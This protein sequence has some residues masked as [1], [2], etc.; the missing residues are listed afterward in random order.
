MKTKLNGI[1]TL[2]LAL[3]VQMT[4]A[5][6]QTVTGTVTDDTGLPLPGVN[7]LVKGTTRGVQTDFDG[8]FAIEARDG[9]VLVFSYL[10]MRT[11]E[12][13][14]RNAGLGIEIILEPD[15]AQLQEVVVTAL[16]IERN[17]RELS[18]SVSSLDNEEITKTRAVNVATA[19]VGK[20][21]GMQINTVN[22]GV[23]PSTRVVL[24]GNRSLLGNNQAL[25]VV[26][27][28]PSERGV[29]DRINPNDIEEMTVLKGA[30]ASALYGS[31]AANGVIVI[32]TKQ[33]RG[34][35]SV[36]YNTSL[37]F[38]NVAYL[39]E[40]QDEF[41]AGGFP[42]GTLYPLE[43]VNWGPRFDG[44]LVDVS[45]TYP[46][47][48]VWQVPFTPIE[49]VHKDFFDTGTTIRNGVTVSGGD[50]SGD[51]LMSVDH[52]NV[53][54]TVPKDTY[55]RTNF[56]FKGSR[57]FE[58]LQVGANL[59]FY[60]S[61]S[62]TVGNGGRQNRPVYWNVINTPL[63]VPLSL[64]KNWRT[65]EFTRNE[66]SFFR[67]YENPYFIID[68][69]RE[70]SDYFQFNVLANADYEFTDWMT[71]SLR[72]GYTGDSQV[73]K[74]EFGGL[75][76]AFR[77]DD[78][79]SNMDDYGARTADNQGT[80]S[81]VNSDFILN[82]DKQITEDFSADL[83][84]G[85]N[86]RLETGN[87]INVS[88]SDLIIPGFY[89][90]STRTGNLDGGQSQSE[91]RRWGVYGDF[92]L[93]FRDYLF[94]NFT[95]RNDWSSTLPEDNRSFF[96]PGGG[97]SFVA[98][99]AFNGMVSSNGLSYLKLNANVTKTGND[100]GLYATAG[101]FFAPSNFPYGSTAGL[102]QSSTEPSPDLNPEFTT[103]YEAGVEFGLFNNR[104]T[105]SA[106]VYQTN[107]TDQIIPVN[108]SYASGATSNLINI[109]E[110]ENQGLELNFQGTIVRT[111]DFIW[112]LGA[113]YTGYRSEV[114]S[115]A[116]GIDE[117]EI[118]GYTYAQ[119][120][121]RVGEPYPM[122]RT[123][124]YERDPQGRVI[125]GEDG[126]PI[127]SSQNQLQGKTTP[128][129]VV[130]LNT[131]INYKNFQLYAVAD[132]RTGH[133]FFN[134]IVNAMEFTGLTQHSVT[135]GRGPFVFPNSSYLNAAGQY[136]ANTNR[137]TTGGG[138]AF[139]DSYNDVAENYVTD[140]T[141]LKL[142]EVSLTYT[143]EE[144][145]LDAIKIDDLTLG[146]FG[147]NLITL[148]PDDN[149]Y[150]DPE[151]NFTTG[152]AIGVGTQSQTPPTRQ[153]GIQLSAKF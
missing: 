133:V 55:N 5:Q 68:T 69:Q 77:L 58:K 97:I 40:F 56:R 82:F 153:Y 106:T 110:I 34:K 93:G 150:T 21:A 10:G 26:D 79:Y 47:G 111:E 13:T 108:T 151:F 101:T 74:R 135:S 116:P 46:D 59:S 50:E 37:Q 62:N 73:F 63:H 123:T 112:N 70:M 41:G 102:A 18:Y 51:F 120:V 137:L 25:I 152:N 127:Q 114:I 66:V 119:I 126:D 30:N 17:P 83:T 38:E 142:R 121:A 85:H 78:A 27:G 65:G 92:T 19:M 139:W 12:F 122:I 103:S 52:S 105:G 57:S 90:V 91:Y 2:L 125:V 31:E 84:L 49:D 54:G 76:Y 115:L 145:I 36:T 96:Y 94:L 140:A 4:F 95:A 129:Y 99:D 109:G 75:T 20:V 146:L 28:F 98:S 7:V 67:F 29:L 143:F 107:S 130:G 61:H 147:R 71:A 87:S 16:G 128:D 15:A 53:T 144:N 86:L 64:M 81:R 1:L 11:V 24:R 45:E 3:V 134:D 14:I 23:N 124:S 113:N 88:G 44:R 100:P 80:S 9:E 43:N 32:T 132:Y 138:N 148:R 42:D 48:R 131:T 35:L 6:T 8:E 104:M 60:R 118:G 89:N 149:V 141:T 136:V 33:G 39:P 72:V 117:L 22:N